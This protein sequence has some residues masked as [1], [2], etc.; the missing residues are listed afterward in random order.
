MK[1]LI[2]VAVVALALAALFAATTLAAGPTSRVAQGYGPGNGFHTPGTGMMM[3][4][5]SIGPGTGA[6]MRGG[7]MRGGAPEWAGIPEEVATLLGMTTEQIQAERQTGKSLAQ[8]AAA[9]D[10]SAGK[11]VETILAAKK[12]DLAPLVTA[13]KLTQTQADTMIERMGAQVKVMVERTT[14]GP[15]NGRGQGGC[16]MGGTPSNATF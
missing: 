2:T 3:P 14:V 9:K 4:G 11:L 5:A 7:M 15:M 10:V 12:A 1:K 13:G 16:G 8:I 6:G